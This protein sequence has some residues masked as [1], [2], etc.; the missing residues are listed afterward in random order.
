M[1]KLTY[2]RN[3]DYLIPDIKF[4]H[5]ES[6]GHSKYACMREIYFS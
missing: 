1:T 3:V 4:T 5:T 2:I 6:L